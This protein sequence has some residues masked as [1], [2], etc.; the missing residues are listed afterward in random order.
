MANI[1]SPVLGQI[2]EADPAVRRPGPFK[3]THSAPTKIAVGILGQSNERGQVVQTDEA[4]FPQAF[5]S[6]RYPGLQA[7][8]NGCI[9]LDGSR[10]R[11][12]SPWF[13]FVD[14]L[15]DAG[16]ETTLFNGSMG[17][18]SMIEH[19]C[20]TVKTRANSTAY[21]YR[22]SP[23][24]LEDFGYAG[25]LIL[26]SGK[27]FLCTTG[28]RN[29]ASTRTQ[30]R[31][32]ATGGTAKTDYIAAFGT[33]ASA[34]SDPGTFAA[35]GL[36]GT[37]TDGS[38]VWTNIDDTNSVG[39]TAGQI[40]S[41]TQ[42]GFGW[43]PYG[44]LERLHANMQRIQHVHSKH[45]ILCNGQS[46]VNATQANYRL[47]LQNV[48]NYFLRRGYYVWVG[49]SCFTPTS[50][51]TAYNTLSAG[52]NDAVT[53]LK[54]GTIYPSRVLTGANLY[55]LMGSSGNMGSGGAYL[56]GDNLH[57]NGAG[58]IEAGRQWGNVFINELPDIVAP[59]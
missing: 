47:A 22:R 5:A 11:L 54:G 34:A 41:E 45:I 27:L 8:I 2:L 52:V 33:Q 19:A 18:M 12:G 51:T 29:V 13:S 42:A 28:R 40:F 21:G 14:T 10:R 26:Q 46:D 44:I 38:V 7:P 37:V 55:S 1:T 59:Q 39:F 48:A 15:A 35:T 50:T 24:D 53:L 3:G 58:A 43:D 4:A 25:D 23:E 6:L 20:G 31:T 9:A 49:L 56:Q 30:Y 17:S 16:F 36:G 32:G 57:L